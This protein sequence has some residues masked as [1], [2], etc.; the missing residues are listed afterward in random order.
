MQLYGLRQLGDDFRAVRR[1]TIRFADEIHE[2]H[3]AYR[4]T[5]ESRSVAETLVHI[6]WL[7]SADQFMHEDQRVVSLGDF[8]FRA[9]IGKSKA[10]EAVPRS[11]AQIIELLHTEGDRWVQWLERVPESF[12]L[13]EVRTPGGGSINRFAMLVGTKEH[14]VQHRGQ[15]AVLKRLIGVQDALSPRAT[16]PPDLPALPSPPARASRAARG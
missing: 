6:A 14:E 11:K 9:L 12:L 10:E 1:D 7:A 5:P 15:L 2:S 13:E 16:R 3:Y 8:D 4:P